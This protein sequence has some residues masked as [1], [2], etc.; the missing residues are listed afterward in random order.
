MTNPEY[1][2]RMKAEDLPFQVRRA[3]QLIEL[4]EMEKHHLGVLGLTEEST[5]EKVR[6]AAITARSQ[7]REKGLKQESERALLW[8][9]HETNDCMNAREFL[10]FLLLD[11][12]FKEIEASRIKDH[13]EIE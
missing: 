5:A 12:E 8:A 13:H 7:I 2:N 9:L 1:L 10:E 6:T 3:G 11:H 4:T